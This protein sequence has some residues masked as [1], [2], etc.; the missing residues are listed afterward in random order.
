M[1]CMDF[2][3][4]NRGMVIIDLA[5]ILVSGYSTARLHMH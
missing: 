5:C 3:P 1:L 4:I 2:L